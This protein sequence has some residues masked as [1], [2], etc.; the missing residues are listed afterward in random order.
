[1]I[2]DKIFY[3]TLFKELFSDTFELKLYDGS[4]EVY[5]Q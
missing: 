4:S 1:M 5:G 3:T 2:I